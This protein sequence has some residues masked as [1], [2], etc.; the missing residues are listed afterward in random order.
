MFKGND[1]G[2]HCLNRYFIILPAVGVLLIIPHLL[3]FKP[4]FPVA[5]LFRV[6][7]IGGAAY[8]SGTILG[9]MFGL[10]RCKNLEKVS[11][12][13][14]SRNNNLI[15]INDWLTKIIVGL[16][17]VNLSKVPD[18]IDQIGE[19]GSLI[20]GGMEGASSSGPILIQCVV[21]YF[22]I[23]GFLTGYLWTNVNYIIILTSMDKEADCIE[24]NFPM[25]TTRKINEILQTECS[26]IS[27]NDIFNKEKSESLAGI[28][29][30]DEWVADQQKLLNDAKI[31]M[32][33]GINRDIDLEDSQKDPNKNMW[34]GSRE[35]EDMVVIPEVKT[36]SPDINY[37][38]V[39]LS[40]NSK[41][42]DKKYP[43]KYFLVTLHNT[44]SDPFKFIAVRDGFAA[45]DFYSYKAYTVGISTVND[46][47]QIVQLEC[48]LSEVVSAPS[49]FRKRE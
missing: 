44:V 22:F 37:Y 29:K 49:E 41:N 43:Y 6:L 24:N 7:V 28:L 42:P 26:Y 30:R 9:F 1:T 2:I 32:L 16:G 5:M 8:L 39:T 14:Y 35:N 38:K 15:E 40:I 19:K 10:P 21:I 46:E 11:S 31:K 47:G 36:I 48:D 33:N 45:I 13:N 18:L 34:G 23:I 12:D 17:L 25:R 27:S 4:P 20:L 3:I